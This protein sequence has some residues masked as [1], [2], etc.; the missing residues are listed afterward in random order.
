MS[1]HGTLGWCKVI[2]CHQEQA[3]SFVT[4]RNRHP[5]G[6][7]LKAEPS[8]TAWTTEPSA[9]LTT[10]AGRGLSGSCVSAQESEGSALLQKHL[11]A[12]HISEVNGWGT[13]YSKLLDPR[14]ICYMIQNSVFHSPKLKLVNPAAVLPPTPHLLLLQCS[15]PDS[16][17]PKGVSLSKG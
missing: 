15:V 13:D 16:I 4:L 9:D 7:E 14:F 10:L 17:K 11:S 2:W 5:H 8:G 6:P 12:W 3:D 1:G